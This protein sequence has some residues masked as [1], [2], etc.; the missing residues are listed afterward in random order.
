M[1]SRFVALAF[2]ATLA[3]ACSAPPRDASSPKGESP[4]ASTVAASAL[5]PNASPSPTADPSQPTHEIQ[6]DV[7]LR[8]KGSTKRV[9]WLYRPKPLPDRL[10]LVIMAPSGMTLLTGAALDEWHRV[11]H[12]PYV[13]ARFAVM[14]YSLD[15]AVRGAD[16]PT[17]SL[18][19]FNAS[20]AGLDNAQQA[21][22]LAFER[23]PSIDRALVFAAGHGSGGTRALYVA[24]ED[25]RIRGV[26]A[27]APPTRINGDGA[28]FAR[29]VDGMLPGYFDLVN[30]VVP[31]NRAADVGGPVW[32]FHATGDAVVPVAHTRAYAKQLRSNGVDVTLAE[33]SGGDHEETA[34]ERG[35]PKAIAWLRAQRDHDGL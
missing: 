21:L 27:Y 33:V 5:S 15:G 8:E 14:A 7:V 3:S 16:I 12:A 10:G 6:I 18:A 32:L 31:E 26:I 17:S 23:L 34:V 24:A 9:F 35:I 29:R 19:A 13:R 4:A 20:K 28:A 2:T 30:R 1:A 22:D 11:E 25:K